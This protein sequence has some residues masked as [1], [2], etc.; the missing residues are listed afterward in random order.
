[1]A[2]HRD[3]SEHAESPGRQSDSAAP[4][5]EIVDAEV[6][7]TP[8][9][10]RRGLPGREERPTGTA[11]SDEEAFREYQQFLEF[12]RFQEWQRRYGDAPPPAT[13]GG[14][15]G[16]AP[17]R[18]WYRRTL[19]LLRF[20]AVRRLLYLLVIVLV[21]MYLYNSMF[22]GGGRDAPRGASGGGG[23]GGSSSAVLQTSPR[24][25]VVSAYDLLAGDSPTDVCL[26]F[27]DAAESEFAA[28]RGAEDCAAA[29]KAIGEE[30][31]DK[32][33]YKNP[34]IARDAAEKIGDRARL[35]S[36]DLRVSG[37]PRLGEFG[38]ARQG[39]GGW[40]IDSYRPAECGG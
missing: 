33:S 14:S 3:P 15:P 34:S 31:T 19:G 25:A 30:I 11:S 22:G 23:G 37:G 28:A 8:D 27:T 21:L 16:E 40:K 39:S 10:P 4:P 38:M 26:L 36:C 6:V 20:K 2:D 13:T 1:M 24:G 5:P 7:P 9:E 17:K 35:S 32:Y 12:R 18:P 29:A